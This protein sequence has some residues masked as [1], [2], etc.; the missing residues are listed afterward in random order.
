M[1]MCVL[2]VNAEEE[3]RTYSHYISSYTIVM[4]FTRSEESKGS[5]FNQGN[6]ERRI[7]LSF[8][9]LST[10]RSYEVEFVVRSS[11]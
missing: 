4:K 10:S 7:F 9:V 11:N 1:C 2:C 6:M 5:N 8:S 3:N